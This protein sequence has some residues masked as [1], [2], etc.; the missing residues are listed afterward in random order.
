MLQHDP[1]L[2]AR[3]PVRY[4]LKRGGERYFPRSVRT[5]E[6][7]TDPQRLDPSP[8]RLPTEDHGAEEL[9]A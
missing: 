6:E 9:Q 3:S 4:I 1:G 8:R 7:S 5:I 2:A